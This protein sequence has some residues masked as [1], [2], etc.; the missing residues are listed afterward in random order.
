[1][2]YVLPD[3]PWDAVVMMR[4]GALSFSRSRRSLLSRN[5]AKWLTAQVSSMPS[6]VS[7]HVPYIAPA[8]LTSTSSFG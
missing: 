6:F 1:M 5:G 3:A 2:G 4:A 8:L 7:C